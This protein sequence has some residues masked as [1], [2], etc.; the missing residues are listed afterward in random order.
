MSTQTIAI[1]EDD[2]DLRE[3]L[4]TFLGG[5]GFTILSAPDGARFRAQ[6]A[7]GRPDL[8]ILDIGLPDDHGYRIMEW[9][10]ERGADCPPIIIVTG[11]SSPRDRITGLDLGADDYVCK[12]FDLGEL[13]SRVRA[14]LRRTAPRPEPAAA[15]SDLHIRFGPWL[16]KRDDR[17]LVHEPDGRTVDLTAMEFDLLCVMAQRPHQVLSRDELLLLAHTRKAEPFDRAIDVRITRLRK[18]IEINP[19]HPGYIRT[20]RGTGYMFHPEGLV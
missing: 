14:V 19:N 18:K 8:V 13:L 1:V 4:A 7:A 9:M 20:I 16:L 12:P 11:A 15:P 6:M 17:V 3:M 10:H 5:H 2:G